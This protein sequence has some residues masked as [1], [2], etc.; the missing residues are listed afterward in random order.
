[1]GK[2]YQAK[3]TQELAYLRYLLS[4]FNMLFQS[5]EEVEVQKNSKE[6]RIPTNLTHLL[7][8]VQLL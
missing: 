2:E 3:S 6:Y 1:M 8:V 5:P 7:D 4:L